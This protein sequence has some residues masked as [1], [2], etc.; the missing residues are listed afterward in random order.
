MFTSRERI[1]AGGKC[2]LLLVLT[3]A[4]TANTSTAAPLMLDF[5]LLS[6]GQGN[7]SIRNHIN[8]QL[9]GGMTVTVSGARTERN[10]TGDSFAVGPVSGRAVTSWTLGNTDFGIPHPDPKDTFLVN[11]G[12]DRI[13]MTFSAPIYAVSFD[14]EIFPHGGMPNGTGHSTSEAAW[15]DFSLL[16]DG[17]EVFR[18]FGV[19]PGAEGTF[20]HSPMS[21]PVAAELA[22]QFL[23]LSG[24]WLFP[25]GVTKLEFVDWPRM[26][27]IDNLLIHDTPIVTQDLPEPTSILLL[28]GGLA[29]LL[30]WRRRALTARGNG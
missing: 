9:L 7:T 21:G 8:G 30:V 17:A 5:N 27:G 29:G 15:P 14:Y 10:Y 23:G 4:G 16:A 20:L 6:S 1:T 19:M 22:P 12:S 2:V 24:L 26:I 13:T 11:S 3:L 25:G 28:S 18:K